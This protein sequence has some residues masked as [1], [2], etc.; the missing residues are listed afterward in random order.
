MSWRRTFERNVVFSY[1]I[2]THAFVSYLQGVDEKVG[3]QIL[4]FSVFLIIYVIK[5]F[6]DCGPWFNI[7]EFY[8]FG[9]WFVSG[10]IFFKINGKSILVNLGVVA[11]CLFY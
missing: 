6:S 4:L 3:G 8:L 7:N 2:Y 10:M 1:I 11:C 5:L 9:I